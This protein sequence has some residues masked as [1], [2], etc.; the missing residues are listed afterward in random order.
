M[1]NKA[2]VSIVI[3]TY[4]RSKLLEGCVNSLLAQT[5]PELEI[6]VVDDGSTD[7][8]HTIVTEIAQKDPRV[9][10]YPR[11]HLGACAARNFGLKQTK[12]EY[13]GFFDSDD[14]WPADYIETMVGNLQANP[15]FDVA[16]SK[17]MQ[18]VDGKI[19]GQYG[20]ISNPPSG[21]LTAEL[22]TGKP[23]ILPSSA[24]FKKNVW[25]GVFWDE[26]LPNR[27]DFDVFLR[28][29]TKTNFM[30]VPQTYT[31]Y[32]STKDGI[33][34]AAKRDLASEN[35]RVM[36]RFYFRLGGNFCIPKKFAFRNLSH[37]YRKNGLEHYNR[38]NKKASIANF[39]KALFYRPL[40]LRL[41]FN[42]LLAVLLN[43]RNDK[44]PDWRTPEALS[45][46]RPDKNLI[47]NNSNAYI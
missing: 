8:T 2:R 32:R 42:L 23:F 25:E 26:S 1:T 4:N 17:I 21:N 43:P 29:S 22:F 18:M 41:Y 16:Y 24:L 20:T 14:L 35:I 44:M 11:P 28:I 39:K 30:Y 34:A 9:R 47:M 37:K 10:Y 33:G 6:I 3:P 19:R 13:I 27:Q 46:P 5:H 15:D 40:D 12:G 31:V 36:E 45:A 38:G 7:D